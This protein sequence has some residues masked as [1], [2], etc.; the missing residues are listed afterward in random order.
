MYHSLYVKE[1]D[2]D[3]LNIK[4][5]INTLI[6]KINIEHFKTECYGSEITM[7]EIRRK[8]W[9]EKKPVVLLRMN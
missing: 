1:E 5:I 7:N 3:R 9:D 2:I 6:K 4:N 8:R